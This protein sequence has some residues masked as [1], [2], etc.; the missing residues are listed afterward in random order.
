MTIAGIAFAVC[1]L[2]AIAYFVGWTPS[3]RTPVAA[4]PTKPP[5]AV[6]TQSGVV[7]L[8]GETL[9]APPGPVVPEAPAAAPAP[10]A[11]APSPPKYTKPAPRT[12]WPALA[13]QP[14]PQYSREERRASAYERSTRS[15]CVNCG[16]V[17]DIARGDYE[18]EVRVRFDDGSRETLRYYDRPRVQVGDPVHLEDGRLVP[19]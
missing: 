18:W 12:P 13:Q 17:T 9:V 2:A 4:A 6:T 11:R 19:D 10:P 14:P 16:V 7:L 1:A 5:Q 15:V 3:S 8:P